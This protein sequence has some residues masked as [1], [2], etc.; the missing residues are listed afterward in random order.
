MEY[1]ICNGL[2]VGEEV[3]LTDK[4]IIELDIYHINITWVI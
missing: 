4:A 1:E 2:E 3:L